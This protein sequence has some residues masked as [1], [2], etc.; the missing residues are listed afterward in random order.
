MALR[1]LQVKKDKSDRKLAEKIVG[2]IKKDK[3]HKL[4]SCVVKSGIHPDSVF[5]SKGQTGLH[6][7][8]KAGHPDC[9]NVFLTKGAST[10]L[11]DNKLNLALHYA[12]KFCL[13]QHSPPPSLVRDLITNPFLDNLELLHVPNRNGTT[14]KILINALN[15]QMCESDSDSSSAQ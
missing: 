9:L 6:L 14:S 10:G 4:K 3:F 13:K 12:A 8:A 11:Q 15:R 1:L 5:N 2:Y 7:A